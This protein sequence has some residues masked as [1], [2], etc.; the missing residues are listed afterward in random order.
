MHSPGISS[1]SRR[2]C[3]SLLTECRR[4]TELP[5]AHTSP[6]SDPGDHSSE[7][8]SRQVGGKRA[9]ATS[10]GAPRRGSHLR[11]PVYLDG[12]ARLSPIL[13]FIPTLTLVPASALI[14]DTSH[15]PHS[16]II[17]GLSSS[18]PL[19]G[20]PS[21]ALQARRQCLVLIPNASHMVRVEVDR[22]SVV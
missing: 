17:N 14:A 22:K 10:P 2:S 11:F 3:W 8:P 7:V 16:S 18:T 1:Y 15:T 20:S 13:W 5:A 12:T 21:M 19:N 6:N 4:L 9:E